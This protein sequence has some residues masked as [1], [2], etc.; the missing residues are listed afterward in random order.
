MATGLLVNGLDDMIQEKHD[1]LHLAKDQKGTATP[2][3][4]TPPTTTVSYQQKAAQGGG[5]PATPST[6]N[7]GGS[8]P[9]FNA[10]AKV[11]GRKVKV[12]GISR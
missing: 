5:T 4:P 10:S 1:S 7:P 9:D 12:L 2:D 8:V 3:A 6:A 11:D